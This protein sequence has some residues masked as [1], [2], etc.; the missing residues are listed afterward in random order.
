[1]M[2]K[3]RT[4]LITGASAGIGRELARTFA[5]EH[6]DLILVAR[7]GDKLEELAKSLHQEFLVKA[8]AIACDLSRAA[9]TEKLLNRIES[10]K[11]LVDALVNNAGFGE[12]G[13]FSET[14]EVREQ[15]MIDLN[16]SALVRLTKYF[17]PQ[18]KKRGSGRILQIA[19]TAAFQPGPFMA[20][21]FATKSFV[22]SFSEAIAE[23]LKGS[24]V[25]VTTICPGPTRTLFQDTP[26]MSGS[27]LFAE[28]NL[29]S[30][31]EVAEFA[32]R[33]MVKGKKVAIHGVKNRI[34]SFFVPITP[35]PLVL[36]IARRLIRGA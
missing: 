15:Q 11:I 36:W 2:L 20:V 29:P 26:G 30:G 4:A 27:K 13:P 21:Y 10:E 12:Y 5:R 16:V 23:E 9:E 17:V 31:Q 7:S 35:R 18:M 22:L 6:Y 19:S 8:T 3:P 33:A 14:N 24:G 28:R 32:Y 34:L 25:T 1:M